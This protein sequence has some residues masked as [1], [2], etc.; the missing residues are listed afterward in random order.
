MGLQL[1]YWSNQFLELKQENLLVSEWTDVL[2]PCIL[3]SGSILNCMTM[4]LR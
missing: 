3:V 2:P 4:M 1:V